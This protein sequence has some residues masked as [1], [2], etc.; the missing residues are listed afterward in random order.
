LVSQYKGRE[1]EDPFDP[2]RHRIVGK[3]I[4]T[5]HPMP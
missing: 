3:V 5:F 2:E 1:E 4:G